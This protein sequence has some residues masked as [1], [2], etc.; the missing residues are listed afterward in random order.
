[1]Q[2][3]I[4]YEFDG[5]LSL[6]KR[7]RNKRNNSIHCISDGTFYQTKTTLMSLARRPHE[8][9]LWMIPVDH[10]TYAQTHK[11]RYKV[12]FACFCIML[13][14]GLSMKRASS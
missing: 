1:M 3:S 2:T 9:V 5:F 6:P 12:I 4:L 11:P 7:A 14:I 10:H 8:I 13:Y